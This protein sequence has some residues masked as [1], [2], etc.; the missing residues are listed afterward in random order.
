M[1]ITISV[2]NRT[3]AFGNMGSI[4]IKKTRNWKMVIL[5]GTWNWK[6]VISIKKANQL[7]I[8]SSFYYLNTTRTLKRSW[9]VS[10]EDLDGILMWSCKGLWADFDW[11]FLESW[12]DLERK[13]PRPHKA[14]P[15]CQYFYLL[16]CIESSTKQQNRAAPP[17]EASRMSA[18]RKGRKL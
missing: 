9:S 7:K 18:T 3:R 10:W 16:L 8:N 12:L 11:I 6:L 15:I 14:A 2:K 17:S 13:P 1:I 5:N 4:S